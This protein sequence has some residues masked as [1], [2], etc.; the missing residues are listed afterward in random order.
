MS[1]GLFSWFH[2]LNWLKSRLTEERNR[3]VINTTGWSGLTYQNGGDDEGAIGQ[4]VCDV[5]PFP[6]GQLCDVETSRRTP[7]PHLRKMKS[8]TLSVPFP[9]VSR[10]PPDSPPPRD[11]LSCISGHW[12]TSP[13]A[14]ADWLIHLYDTRF[15]SWC[16]EE[17]VRCEASNWIDTEG[18]T[19]LRSS[20]DA[21]YEII[22]DMFH[23][24]KIRK[25]WMLSDF[26]SFCICHFNV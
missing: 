23:F 24:T 9:T 4:R 25:S 17:V 5:H 18:R 10:D 8:M 2:P 20:S 1:S 14:L 16:K 12:D 19:I 3:A 26:I 15:G 22:M 13:A 7:L 11:P 6:F 21:D